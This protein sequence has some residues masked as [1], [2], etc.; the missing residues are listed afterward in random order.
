MVKTA[1][2]RSVRLAADD[3]AVHRLDE[4][5]RDGEPEAGAG[6]D[7]V[8]LLRAVELVEDV[9]EIVR[10]NAA[11]FVEHAQA[12]RV[13]RCASPECG[14]SF[15]RRVFRG[16]VEE[17]EQ[18]LLEQH[19]IE[20]EHRQIRSELELDLVAR[21]DAA[22]AAQRAADDLAESCKR[23]VRRD[24][25]GFELGHVE[26]IGD[27]AV[28]PLRLVDDRRQEV[29]LL[30]IAELVARMSR[31]VPAAP[32]TAASGVFRS[33]EIEVSSAERKRSVSAARST[34]SIS[35]TSLHPL[36]RERALV[37][38][39]VEQPP[40]VGRE[41]RTGLVAV[42]AH[43]ADGAAPGAHRQEQALGAGQRIGAATGGTVVLPRPLR[44]AAR[45]ASSRMSSGG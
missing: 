6:A 11:S 7:L 27:E 35:S 28:E 18:H 40:L 12:D 22:G 2:L 45:S 4:A 23:D 15:R 31:S 36:D 38:Q 14:S 37:E 9:L 8:G 32:S 33:W 39:R 44:P 26:Q 34:R 16:I 20:F 42:D 13:R 17:V 10:R 1:P 41:Q 24:R 21:Q 19:G 43:H 3:G 5:A 25:A 29:R 30:A